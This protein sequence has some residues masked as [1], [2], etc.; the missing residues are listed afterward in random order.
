MIYQHVKNLT[1]L[2]L[3]NCDSLPQGQF[4]KLYIKYDFVKAQSKKHVGITRRL[5]SI[6][7]SFRVYFFFIVKCSLHTAQTKL[8]RLNKCRT[9]IIKFDCCIYCKY[10][11]IIADA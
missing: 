9:A 11:C 10:E 3:I 4:C 7:K 2:K 6:V 8:L 1:E 5:I